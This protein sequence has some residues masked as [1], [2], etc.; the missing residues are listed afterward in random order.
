MGAILNNERKVAFRAALEAGKF[1]Q[2]RVGDIKQIDYKSAFNLVTDVDKA[3]EEMILKIILGEFPDD[4]IVAEESGISQ[5]K[6]KRIWYIDPV[7]GTTN[8]AHSYPFFAVS[9]GLEVDGVRTLGVVYN[10]S[11]DEMFWALKGEGARLND[12]PIIVSSIET[13]E[14]SLLATGFPPNTAEAEHANMEQFKRLTGLSHGVRRDGSAAL[15]L[16]FV[17]CGR[18]DG[19]WE[20]KLSPWDIAAG[21]LIVEEAGGTVSDFHKGPLSLER[22]NILATNGLVHNEI[23]EALDDKL[24]PQF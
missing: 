22:G 3:S 9:I 4:Q 16:C 11:A 8:F 1:I 7:D 13:L 20:R 17:A 6:S 5:K 19:F 18:L 21:S 12:Q 2:S 23:I 15:D 24:I 10:P 14:T